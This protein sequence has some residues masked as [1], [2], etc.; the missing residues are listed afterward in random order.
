M[1]MVPHGRVKKKFLVIWTIE[2]EQSWLEHDFQNETIHT[3]TLSNQIY[4]RESRGVD[5]MLRML[6]LGLNSSK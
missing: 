3:C 1:T 4:G 2:T 6:L 5:S